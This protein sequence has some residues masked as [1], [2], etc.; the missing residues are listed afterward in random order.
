[1]QENDYRVLPNFASRIQQ[2]LPLNI[3]GRGTQ[4]RTFY[5]SDALYGF[6]CDCQWRDWKRL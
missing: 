2:G 6:A 5:I 1:M 4:T 3:Y